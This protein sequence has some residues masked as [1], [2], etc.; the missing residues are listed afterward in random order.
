MKRNKLA[1]GLFM[2]VLVAFAVGSL[3]HAKG[4]A[5][6]NQINIGDSI[7][8]HN[9]RQKTPHSARKAAAARLKGVYETAVAE[10]TA[11]Q[12]KEHGHHGRSK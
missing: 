6:Q 1:T 5:T 7:Q 8:T 9:Q 12:V 4:P 11:R 10:D 3:A 2:T